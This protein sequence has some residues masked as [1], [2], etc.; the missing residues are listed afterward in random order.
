MCAWVRAKVD[1]RAFVLRREKPS[2]ASLAEQ[3][4]QERFSL[5]HENLTQRR[6]TDAE[7]GHH[8]SYINSQVHH[9]YFITTKQLIVSFSTAK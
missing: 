1:V 9:N 6:S 2:V 7:T 4:L 5:H 3:F 8:T